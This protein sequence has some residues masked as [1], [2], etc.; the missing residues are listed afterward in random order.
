MRVQEYGYR[1]K[2]KRCC[3]SPDC[4]VNKKCCENIVFRYKIDID[5]Y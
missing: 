1:K 5:K 3:K 4:F 2:R